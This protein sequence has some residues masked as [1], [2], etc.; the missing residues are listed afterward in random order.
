MIV[1][2]YMG[3]AFPSGVG[4][5]SLLIR[6]IRTRV[7]FREDDCEWRGDNLVRFFFFLF[8][9]GAPDCGACRLQLSLVKGIMFAAPIMR[10]LVE[11]ERQAM[12]SSEAHESLRKEVIIIVFRAHVS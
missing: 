10:V 3:K 4:D 2:I 5:D 11:V 8:C 12:A 7:R 1:S 6:R 9:H